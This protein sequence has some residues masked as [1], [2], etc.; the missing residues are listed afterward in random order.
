MNIIIIVIVVIA[1]LWL[2]IY[3][4]YMRSKYK[5]IYN[6]PRWWKTPTT[7]DEF[8]RQIFEILTECDKY[9]P[10]WFENQVNKVNERIERNKGR[11]SGVGGLGPAGGVGG[12]MTWLTTRAGNYFMAIGGIVVACLGLI[13]ISIGIVDSSFRGIFLF[14]LPF[15]VMVLVL[16]II[17]D[18]RGAQATLGVKLTPLYDLWRKKMNIFDSTLR[19]KATAEEIEVFENVKSAVLKQLKETQVF[20]DKLIKQEAISITIASFKST[21]A[22]AIA[23][24]GAVIAVGALIGLAAATQ[25]MQ[26]YE[27]IDRSTGQKWDYDPR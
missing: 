4:L 15:A 21:L 3:S 9:L 16:R 24:S 7:T 5:E 2:V 8:F 13:G 25:P 1:V 6:D 27:Y 17:M 22:T 23:V 12:G 19:Q 18:K 26:K 11:A 14:T 20:Q 10:A